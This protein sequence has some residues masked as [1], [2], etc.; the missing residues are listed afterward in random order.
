MSERIT[1]K[2]TLGDGE[3]VLKAVAEAL[4]PEQREALLDNL[5]AQL[6]EQC[7]PEQLEQVQGIIGAELERRRTLASA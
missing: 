7:T 2:L 4:P 5:W 3:T 6:K 1:L